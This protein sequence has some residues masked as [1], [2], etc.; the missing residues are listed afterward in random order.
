MLGKCGVNR[1]DKPRRMPAPHMV[2]TVCSDQARNG[3]TL[4][5]RVLVDFLLTEGRD[6]FCFDLGHSE[7]SLRAYFPGRT[8]LFDFAMPDGQARVLDTILARAG[9]DYVIDL[10]A[11]H[12]ARFCEK[13]GG[14]TFAAKARAQ[15]FRLVTLFV[16]DRDEKSLTTAV[17]VEDILMPDIFVPV[18]NRFVGTALPEGVPG[19]VLVMERLEDELEAVISHRRFSFRAFMQGD[20][21]AVPL[22]YRTSLKNFLHRLVT[23]MREFEPALSLQALRETSP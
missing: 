12:L 13:V 21:A 9:R 22:R 6:P 5:T 3:K 20:E 23:G 1:I 10:P 16:V 18:A 7:R 15:E 4:L 14:S 11:R 2:F 17:A 8:A 19:P